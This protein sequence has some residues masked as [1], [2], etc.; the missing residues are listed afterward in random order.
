V[1]LLAFVAERRPAVRRGA[2]DRYL[3]PA[4]G[5]AANPPH[6]AA[7]I[8]ID[9]TDRRTPYR[10]TDPPHTT[11]AVVIIEFIA[12]LFSLTIIEQTLYSVEYSTATLNL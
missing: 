11:R 12:Q 7:A 1:T 2:V 10:Y 6:A 8:D 5:P 3:L 9:G 4:G